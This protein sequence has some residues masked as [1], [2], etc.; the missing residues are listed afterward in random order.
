MKKTGM[1]FLYGG[2]FLS[3]YVVPRLLLTSV[4]FGWGSLIYWIL[5]VLSALFVSRQE[6]WTTRHV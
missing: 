4:S 3:L 6:H 5:F 1:L 2:L